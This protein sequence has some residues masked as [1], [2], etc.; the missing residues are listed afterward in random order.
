MPFHLLAYGWNQVHTVRFG[1]GREGTG[2]L[3]ELCRYISVDV[4]KE[5]PLTA[6]RAHAA[7]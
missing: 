5:D 4:Q 1:D 7:P 3:I 2:T 6:N